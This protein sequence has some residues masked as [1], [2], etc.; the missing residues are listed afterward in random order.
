[1]HTLIT[2]FCPQADPLYLVPRLEQALTRITNVQIRKQTGELEKMQNMQSKY[3]VARNL[4]VVYHD[5]ETGQPRIVIEFIY[6]AV[7]RAI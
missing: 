6:M 4:N 3:T 5:P 1:V 7:E 2:S